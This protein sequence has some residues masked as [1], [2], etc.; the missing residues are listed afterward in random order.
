MSWGVNTEGLEVVSART[1]KLGASDRVFGSLDWGC[2]LWRF[3]G[4]NDRLKP[5]HQRVLHSSVPIPL[6][7][8]LRWWGTR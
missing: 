7:I 6:S 4:F 5:I 1:P 8:L 3:L 2:S